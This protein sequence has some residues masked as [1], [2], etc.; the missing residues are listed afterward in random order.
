MTTITEKDFKKL[1]VAHEFGQLSEF[2]GRDIEIY[3]SIDYKNTAL[4]FTEVEDSDRRNALAF[5]ELIKFGGDGDHQVYIRFPN[6]DYFVEMDGGGHGSG[7]GN[8]ITASGKNAWETKY[9]QSFKVM[10]HSPQLL[11]MIGDFEFNFMQKIA[12]YDKGNPFNANYPQVTS[13]NADEIERVLR[14]KY[15]K[16]PES[17]RVIEYVFKTKDEK[18]KYFIA[19]Y[20]AYNFKYDNHR[21][22]MI[23]EDVVTDLVID[24]FVRYKD[25]GTTI[26][27]TKDGNKLFAPQT[28]F[29]TEDKLIPK[30]NDIELVEVE[31]EAERNYVIEPLKMNL[32][33]SREDKDEPRFNEKELQMAFDDAVEITGNKHSGDAKLWLKYPTYK[34]WRDKKFKLRHVDDERFQ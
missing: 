22:R 16:L 10:Y 27:T 1:E 33:P 8:M 11:L 23:Q 13:M 2:H 25:G 17:V 15:L 6:T 3:K 21:L 24:K 31:D 32:A 12:G 29:P 30:W 9:K 20:P 4:Y 19:D 7:R 28:M 26:I 14:M 34:D 18:P 5:F